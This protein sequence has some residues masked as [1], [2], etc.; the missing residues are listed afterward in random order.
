MRTDWLIAYTNL[1]QHYKDRNEANF[2]RLAFD[3]IAERMARDE[4]ITLLKA[5]EHLN[6]LV[7][8]KY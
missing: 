2:A 5:K 8:V 6:T 4:R 3:D 7:L 1:K